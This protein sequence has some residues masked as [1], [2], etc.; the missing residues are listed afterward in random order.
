MEFLL[1]QQRPAL[2]Q[3]CNK[4]KCNYLLG[5]L[6]EFLILL[7]I[8]LFLICRL[9]KI[10]IYTYYTRVLYISYCP[11]RNENTYSFIHLQINPPRTLAAQSRKKHNLW[12]STDAAVT[13]HPAVPSPG[14]ETSMAS[15][16]GARKLHDYRLS[17][18]FTSGYFSYLVSDCFTFS[19]ISYQLFIQEYLMIYSIYSICI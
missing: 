9:K 18:W 6:R 8:I 10:A 2:L 7:R 16:C 17:E 15:I 19:G 5:I 13:D 3:R 12:L 14:C 11:L 4:A 1:G